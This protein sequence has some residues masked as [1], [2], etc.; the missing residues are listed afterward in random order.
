MFLCSEPSAEC[1]RTYFP[2]YASAKHLNIPFPQVSVPKP[3]VLYWP[4]N[5]S[6]VSTGLWLLA[7]TDIYAAKQPQ[8][9]KPGPV[10][11]ILLSMC[12]RCSNVHVLPLFKL[13]SPM[14]SFLF[15]ASSHLS[16]TPPERRA[17]YS[18]WRLQSAGNSCQH[19]HGR[20]RFDAHKESWISGCFQCS[21]CDM[22]K[23]TPLN[24]SG[25]SSNFQS[26]FSSKQFSQPL[27]GVRLFKRGGS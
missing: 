24:S 25:G 26:R 6:A 12:P 1:K 17:S 9:P 5:H 23:I 3:I 18:L 21:P 4:P 14:R 7:A 11:R 27:K 13:F 15:P 10:S 22:T 19:T 16:P 20:S 2:T 8:C